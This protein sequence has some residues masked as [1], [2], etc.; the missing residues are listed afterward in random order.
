MDIERFDTKPFDVVMF[1]DKGDMEKFS[2]YPSNLVQN[3]QIQ[4]KGNDPLKSDLTLLYFD[5]RNSK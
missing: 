4:L 1:S 3:S 2:S 5:G